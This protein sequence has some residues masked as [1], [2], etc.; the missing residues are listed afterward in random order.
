[1][2]KRLGGLGTKKAKK[3]RK[4]KQVKGKANKKAAGGRVTP[5][6]SARVTEGGKARTTPLMLPGLDRLEKDDL[7]KLAADLDDLGR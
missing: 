6:T 2:M 5:K 3:G 1:M 7:E 4:D